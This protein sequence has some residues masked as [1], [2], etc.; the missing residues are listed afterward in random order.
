M[1][2][3]TT[4]A[5]Q[6]AINDIL[7]RQSDLSDTQAHVAS[8]KRIMNAS[9]DPV[10]AAQVLKLQ[11]VEA[12]NQQYSR[13]IDSASNR[14]GLEE[15]S[16]DQVTGI[17]Q[18]VRTLALQGTN[19]SQTRDDRTAAASELRQLFSQLV[20]TTNA[21]DA[22]GDALFAG[23]AVRATPFVQGAGFSVSYAGDDGQ[24]MV[25][26]APGMQ[27]ATGDPG[28]NL[29]MDIPAGNGRFAVAA[30]ASNTGSVVVGASSVT[31]MQ[32]YVP[33]NYTITFTAA[34]QWQAKDS[35]GTIVANGNYDGSGAI[36][37]NG[38]QISLDGNA[39]VGDTL[40]VQGGATQDMFSSIGK[41]IDTFEN[42]PPGPAS[43]NIVNR[44]IEGIDQSL[45]RVLDVQAR[46]GARMNTLDTQKS[47]SGDLSVQNQSAISQLGDLDMASAIS[48]LNLQS[49][50]LQAAQQT[51]VKVQGMSLF[52]Y[53]K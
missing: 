29:F 8:G 41:L 42:T 12:A 32:A 51:Y 27:V 3:S 45:Q 25:A 43:A 37:F 36:A 33:G 35:S 38:M 14:L 49:V 2:I 17:L 16:L 31:D 47:T 5:Q 13:N 28:S 26:A 18:R 4:W 23:N 9:D 53:L 21:T 15:T 39:A 44:Q 10:A 50:A 11:H 24:R 30:G 52:D 40:Q 19:A 20:Q 22:Q 34:D 7:N 48:K 46:V 6:R 1:R